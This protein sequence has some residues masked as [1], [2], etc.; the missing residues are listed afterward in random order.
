MI[1]R[2]LAVG[3]LMAAVLSTPPAAAIDEHDAARAART[4]RETMPLE[5]IL[6]RVLGE[7]V[8]VLDAELERTPSSYRYRLKLLEHGHRVRI[9][10]VD[11]RTGV[12]V[13][14]D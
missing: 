1:A 14:D 10:I 3:G 6:E 13:K 7:D 12:V 5:T 2:C 4:T 11:G 8:T 9:L